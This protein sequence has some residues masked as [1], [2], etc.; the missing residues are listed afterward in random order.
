M[1]EKNTVKA[2]KEKAHIKISD[3]AT[4]LK[5]AELDKMDKITVHKKKKC[6]PHVR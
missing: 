6:A 1:G 3:N 4:E 5:R 2:E